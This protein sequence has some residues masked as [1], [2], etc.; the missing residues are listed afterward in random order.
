MAALLQKHWKTCLWLCWTFKLGKLIMEDPGWPRNRKKEEKKNPAMH[1]YFTCDPKLSVSVPYNPM[2]VI[3]FFGSVEVISSLFPAVFKSQFRSYYLLCSAS[4]LPHSV[5][6]TW[7]DV[8]V[9]IYF[10]IQQSTW[11]SDSDEEHDCPAALW[12]SEGPMSSKT[13]GMQNKGG[14]GCST[15]PWAMLPAQELDA[16]AF[17][18]NGFV[19]RFI[20]IFGKLWSLH[21]SKL[22]S[23]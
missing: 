1:E 7:S 10:I 18:R 20:A 12:L 8:S 14:P 3:I 5:L 19:L 11:I 21:R 16:C 9:Y 15:P 6:T 2:K 13:S 4:W 23:G 22:Y 17:E